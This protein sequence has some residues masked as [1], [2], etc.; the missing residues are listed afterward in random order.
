MSVGR[1]KRN[2]YNIRR[3][4]VIFNKIRIKERETYD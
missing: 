3:N 2:A 1:K 4:D